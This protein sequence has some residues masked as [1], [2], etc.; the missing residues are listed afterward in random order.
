MKTLKEIGIKPSIDLLDRMDGNVESCNQLT[1][2][3]AVAEECGWTFGD[4]GWYGWFASKVN[5]YGGKIVYEDNKET[6]Q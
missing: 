2:A 3:E 1:Q 6:S 5:R 4:S